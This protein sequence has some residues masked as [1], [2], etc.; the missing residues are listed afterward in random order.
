MGEHDESDE[1]FFAVRRVRAGKS[2][3]MCLDARCWNKLQLFKYF[4]P[5]VVVVKVCEMIKIK[6][7]L[8]ISFGD[9]INDK[10]ALGLKL[11]QN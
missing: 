3:V 2:L 4:F 7:E 9:F 6:R 11:E 10:N 1:F 8:L 5:R